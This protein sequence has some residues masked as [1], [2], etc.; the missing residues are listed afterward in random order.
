MVEW[1]LAGGNGV[2]FLCFSE[3]KMLW[4]LGMKVFVLILPSQAA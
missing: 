3:A 1:G 2:Y 4:Q